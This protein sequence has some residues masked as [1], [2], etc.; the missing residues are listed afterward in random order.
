MATIDVLVVGSGIAGLTLAIKAA[1]QFPERKVVILTKDAA[2]ESNTRYA[3]GGIAVVSDKIKDSFERHEEDTCEA[4]DGLCDAAIVSKVVR[5][6]PARLNELI[7]MGVEFDRDQTGD[8]CL[9]REGGHQ[10]HRVIHWQDSTGLQLSKALLVKV[11]QLPNIELIQYRL[12]L[13]LITTQVGVSTSNIDE[14]LCVGLKVLN[15]QTNEIEMY[16][17]HI[18]V[19]ATGG[20]GQLYSA[21]TNPLVATGDGI[22]IAF[23]AGARISNM[24]FIQF[25]PTTL[26]DDKAGPAFL[27]SEAIR[28]HGAYLRNNK[29]ERF[30]FRYHTNG[31][32]ACRDIVSRAIAGEI[33][34]G[35]A[36]VVYLDCTHIANVELCFPTIYRTCLSR[37][38]D[39]R[40]DLL[41]VAPAAH[42]LCG[43][44]DVDVNGRTSIQNLYACGECSN[45][46]LHGAN[47]LA[48]NSL[49]EALV[50]AHA[51]YLDIGELFEKNYSSQQFAES[52]LEYPTDE[53][54]L[55]LH[56][57]KLSLQNLM[58]KYVGIVRNNQGLRYAHDQIRILEEKMTV[59]GKDYLHSQSWCELRNMVCCAKLI[60]EHSR[61]RK[62]NRGVFFNRD[63]GR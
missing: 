47:R 9:S 24:E 52:I 43:G 10:A 51:C 12:A 4:G 6:A 33:Q 50:F 8:F 44:I 45:T 60:V 1:Q 5:E 20:L 61:Q 49:L 56:E 27:I 26:K 11:K 7:G 19:M 30:L 62:V 42:Y 55:S 57:I 39:L 38:I 29:G 16:H 25:H 3:Q 48:S 21:T 22:G 31:E 34:S 37:G 23:R 17:A 18:T 36:E 2:D 13:D 54:D 35:D 46:G 41:P 15:L 63:I 53:P 40:F 59:G 14:K 28:G 58:T 32:L